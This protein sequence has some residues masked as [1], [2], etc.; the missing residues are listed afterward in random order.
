MATKT[1]TEVLQAAQDEALKLIEPPPKVEQVD[2]GD[3]TM[4]GDLGPLIV[5]VCTKLCPAVRKIL[6]TQT[7]GIAYW[8][9]ELGLVQHGVSLGENWHHVF[10]PRCEDLAELKLNKATQDS[11]PAI[12]NKSEWSP[13]TSPAKALRSHKSLADCRVEVAEWEAVL[14]DGSTWKE[15]LIKNTGATSEDQMSDAVAKASISASRVVWHGYF[16]GMSQSTAVGAAANEAQALACLADL[17]G[18]YSPVEKVLAGG[19][20]KK[21]LPTVFPTV[22]DAAAPGVAPGPNSLIAKWMTPNDATSAM[23]QPALSLATPLSN[24]QQLVLDSLQDTPAKAAEL[25]ASLFR[26]NPPLLAYMTDV[27]MRQKDVQGFVIEITPPG[28]EKDVNFDALT[29]AAG[30]GSWCYTLGY[31]LARWT[32]WLS[33]ATGPL[34]DPEQQ[35]R[36]EHGMVSIVLR[37][38]SEMNSHAGEKN[39]YFVDLSDSK[40]PSATAYRTAFNVLQG[41]SR[42]GWAAGLVDGGSTVPEMS[43]ALQFAIIPM[44]RSLGGKPVTKD[45]ALLLMP[46]SVE[47]PKSNPTVEFVGV[48]LYAGANPAGPSLDSVKNLALAAFEKYKKPSKLLLA[49]AGFPHARWNEWAYYNEVFLTS[50]SSDAVD[51]KDSAVTH[52]RSLAD[53]APALNVYRICDGVKALMIALLDVYKQTIPDVVSPKSVICW[54]G[55]N[56]QYLEGAGSQSPYVTNYSWLPSEQDRFPLNYWQTLHGLDSGAPEAA[57]VFWMAWFF[58]LITKG[59]KTVAADGTTTTVAPA[60]ASGYTKCYTEFLSKGPP[61]VFS[62]TELAAIGKHL[63]NGA[64]PNKYSSDFPATITAGDVTL[65]TTASTV[66]D[67]TAFFDKWRETVVQWL[68]RRGAPGMLLKSL[69]DVAGKDIS[70]SKYET[71]V[72]KDLRAYDVDQPFNTMSGV[73]TAFHE[74]T[75][76]TSIESFVATG[77]VDGATPAT[78]PSLVEAFYVAKVVAS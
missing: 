12:A 58:S 44:S 30:F 59:S 41:M 4:V 53:F 63:P 16:L 75:N 8:S 50:T 14:Q 7:L 78:W 49:E 18:D 21:A 10:G 67:F 73:L 31:T 52:Y 60:A 19:D 72:Q 54:F 36:F 33:K 22:F 11:F 76:G 25:A 45:E 39:G 13:F 43:D 61:V 71:A 57:K 17:L 5:W 35:C 6:S 1:K 40:S 55:P 34:A 65:L 9:D 15:W 29:T 42:S 66:K 26:P 62:P 69:T 24:K 28:T 27:V 46:T 51:Y 56:K 23:L 48:D 68:L 74:A 2:L 64:D 47:F 38:A 77:K 3:G 20:F 32:C 37:F 70:P